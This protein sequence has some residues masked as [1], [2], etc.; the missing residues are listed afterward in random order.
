ML[1]KGNLYKKVYVVVVNT[2]IRIQIY[3][4][5]L[6]KIAST[7]KITLLPPL[8]VYAEE[9]FAPLLRGVLLTENK[10]NG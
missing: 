8:L 9:G 5:I 3:R 6:Y 4:V 7:Y 10:R 1:F 2:Y